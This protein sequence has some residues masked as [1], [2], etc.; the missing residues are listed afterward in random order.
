MLKS[1]VEIFANIIIATHHV[2][3]FHRELIRIGVMKSYPLHALYLRHFIDRMYQ[4]NHPGDGDKP[5]TSSAQ[6]S[7]RKRLK[8]NLAVRNFPT[9]V[10]VL[11]RQLRLDEGGEAYLFAT[12]LGN[13][14]HV[15][16]R[17]RKV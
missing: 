15:L 4:D 13:G 5:M 10:A 14:Q 2:K 9:S 6:S 17:C 3:Q 7:G 16:I 8:A 1:Y 11:R 12:T